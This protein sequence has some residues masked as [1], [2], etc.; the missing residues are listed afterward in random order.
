[1]S[2]LELA[3]TVITFTGLAGIIGQRA[4]ARRAGR[5]VKRW[6]VAL[7]IAVMVIGIALAIT[8]VSTGV[9]SLF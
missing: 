8:G 2:L 6:V 4:A 7:S 1:V 9:V 3:A 5:P